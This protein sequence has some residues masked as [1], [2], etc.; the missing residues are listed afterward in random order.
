M[1]RG[2][3]LAILLAAFNCLPALAENVPRSINE[4]VVLALKHSAELAALEKEAT[5]KQSLAI[6]AGTISNPTLELQGVT[7]SLTG[8]PEE[9]SVSIGINQELPLY[10]KLRLRREA[11]QREAEAAQR[12]RDN[13][14]RLLKD[15]ISTVALDFSL[16]AKRQELA[17]EL[18]KLNRDLVAISGERFKAGDIPELDFNLTKVELARA[19]SRLLEVERERIPLRIKIAS[20]TGLNESDINLSD[21][22]SAPMPSP[23]P[24][25]QDT[26]VN[27]VMFCQ[28]T[29]EH[30]FL[31]TKTQELVKQALAS[32]P[33][34]LAL[35]LERDRA[36][37]ET[38]LAKAEAIPNLTVGLF[39]QWQRGST[40]LGGLSS[41]SS[42]T[43]FGLRLSMPIPVFDRNKGGRAAAQAH[44]DAADS[45]RLALERT[46]TAEVEAAL[47][48][49][50]SSERILSLLEQGII[51]QLT[52][53]LKLTQE[54]YRL[55][56]VGILSVIDEQKKFFE[57]NDSYLS[58]LHGRRAAFIKLETAAAIDLSGGM[59]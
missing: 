23:S 56:E 25:K 16:T 46:I 33:D 2:T 6:Q 19:E 43:Q 59:Q 48:R 15:E 21:K 12:Q 55:G 18:V 51:P 52:E 13:T 24:D 39:A 44:L 30:T 42:D 11:G 58:A 49:L 31:P 17:A 1:A 20:L 22:L 57:V 34:L 3:A 47:S 26:C 35:A 38:R 4:I 14:A 8:S 5:A 50:A 36:E 9:H 45:R 54:A 53:N 41:T 7:G 40:E 32:R 28:N 29:S 27:D 10:G 37:T